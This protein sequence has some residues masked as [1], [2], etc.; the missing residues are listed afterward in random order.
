MQK[1]I[2]LT[3][4]TSLL[5][6][7]SA[8][9]K[10]VPSS[11]ASKLARL[12]FASKGG[13]AASLKMDSITFG[14]KNYVYVFN[15][16]QEDGF[17]LVSADDVAM[18]FWGYGLDANF[19]YSPKRTNTA[20]WIENIA[21]EVK[22][23]YQNNI[24]ANEETKQAWKNAESGIFGVKG[25]RVAAVLP[26]I[27]SRWNQD[28]Y[29]NDLCP[30]DNTA[31]ERTVVG[32]VA[33]CMSQ[34][35]KFWNHPAQGVGNHQY[36]PS[37]YPQQ[38]ANFGLTTYNWANMPN[39]ITSPNID[40]AT[41]CYQVGVACDMSYGVG[42]TGGSGAYTT[43]A[44]SPTRNCAE[45]AL[46]T[47]FKYDP[48]TLRG[49]AKRDYNTTAW[50]NLLKTE[51]NARRPIMYDGYGTGG[52]HSFVCD[53][54]DDTDMFHF[55]WGWGGSS[56]GYF[57]TSALNPGS[58]GTGGG[59]G[60]FNS[61]QNVIIGIK[62][63]I[64]NTTARPSIAMNAGISVTGTPFQ[65]LSSISASTTL[66]N[67]GTAAFRGDIIACAFS[68]STLVAGIDTLYNVSI[69]INQSSGA[70]NFA[71]ATGIV[72]LIQ[73]DYTLYIYCKSETDSAWTPVSNRNAYINGRSFT[74]VNNNT[75][76]L[77]SPLV[78]PSSYTSRTPCSVSCNVVNN[79]TSTFTG[80]ISLS[81]YDLNG[82]FV[83]D[84]QTYTNQTLRSGYRFS[85]DVV[86]STDSLNVPAGTYVLV[87]TYID[88]QGNFDI[89]GSG[90]NLFNP[91]FITVVDPTSPPDRYESNNS[92]NTAASLTL[93][94]G[95]SNYTASTTS[96]NFHIGTDV[97]YYKIT[98][99]TGFTYTINARLQDSYDNNDG[100]AY[101]VDALFS[102]ALGN[103][104]TLSS[105]FDTR[106]DAPFTV[107]GGKV[108]FKV[109]PFFQG[110]TGSYKLDL[111]IT[112]GPLS[113]ESDL[114]TAPIK[115]YPNPASGYVK[116]SAPLLTHGLIQIYNTAGQLVSSQVQNQTE[117]TI[118]T[119]VLTPGI[120]M[121]HISGDERK[122]QVKLVV[123]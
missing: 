35:M 25:G 43:I 48:S 119:E 57:A 18:P 76:K 71:S 90:P 2:L 31:N 11:T 96:S 67:T 68:G 79:S 8:L 3:V 70:L 123:K 12:F 13:D 61:G 28:P 45:Y 115:L 50:K 106:L 109:A 108:V 87:L 63:F 81:V 103:D 42:S 60:G 22:Y 80:S 36:T 100:G 120:Y 72:P 94:G 110:N 39:R 30:Y 89:V 98:L 37:N 69:G 65:Y 121:V 97:D 84:I 55:N 38:S 9:A 21:N 34:V 112:Q 86:F 114:L 19:T 111:T 62:P 33:T 1:R 93:V 40:V 75:F 51:L 102:Y 47:Y 74:V 104:S 16:P 15:A 117:E 78:G 52:G 58:L 82:F 41:L 64:E 7:L 99:P 53:G 59:A 113:T 107:N 88:S 101:T 66:T 6:M 29:Y 92:F 77:Y 46:K 118:N 122:A 73:G 23:A 54:Y 4:T 27:Q 95:N 20:W 85:S 56:N 14:G 49:L 105:P 116:I 10:P 83:Y 24:V 5:V 17:V 91:I 44:T 26:L 32:C